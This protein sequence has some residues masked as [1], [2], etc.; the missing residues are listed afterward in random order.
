[1]VVVFQIKFY[2][3]HVHSWQTGMLHRD[4]GDP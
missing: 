4:N 2:L 1:M 3:L